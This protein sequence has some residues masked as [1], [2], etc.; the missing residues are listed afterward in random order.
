MKGL[1]NLSFKPLLVF[2]FIA[3]FLLLSLFERDLFAA[4]P[5]KIGLTLGLTGRYAEMS[6][7]QRKGFELWVS[8]VNKKG[9]F[10]GREIRLI[11]Y[12]DKSDPTVAK[13]LYE[14]MIDKEGV[15]LIFAPYSSEMLPQ[16]MQQVN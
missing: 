5:L 6:E 12:D 14:A 16:P 8:E 3:T 7:M 2:F 4:P 10:L 15:D 11:T 1:S 13:R 9:G